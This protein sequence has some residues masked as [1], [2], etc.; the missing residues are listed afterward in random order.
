MKKE[1]KETIK[2]LIV[3]FIIGG[4]VIS[5]VKYSATHI[6]NPG[7]AA[8]IGGVPTGLVSII[9]LDRIQSQSYSENYF[10][11]TLSLLFSIAVY[12]FLI[13]KTKLN[14]KIVWII[15]LLC[16]AILVAAHYF[17]VKNNKNKN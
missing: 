6:N 15:S 14:M 17:L 9:L 3:P 8:I 16:W 7:L 5:G 12:Y 10:F 2:G 13:G 4:A 11:V 1:T